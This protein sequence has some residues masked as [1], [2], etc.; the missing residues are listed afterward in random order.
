M[1]LSIIISKP[2]KIAYNFSKMFQPIIFLN[3][4][5]KLTKKIISVRL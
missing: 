4:L 2:N 1:S 3:T 5:E